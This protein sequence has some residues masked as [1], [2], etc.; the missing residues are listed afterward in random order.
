MECLPRVACSALR[1]PATSLRFRPP[2]SPDN[3]LR[4]LR[5][6]RP[7]GRRTRSSCS[8][9]LRSVSRTVCCTWG[10]LMPRCPAAS[11]ATSFKIRMLSFSTIGLADLAG[12]Q[13]KHHALQDRVGLR[14]IQGRFGNVAQIATG[15]RGIR[16][17]GIIHRQRR[18]IRAA[19][20]LV[21]NIFALRC[22]SA[23]LVA[24]SFLR[25]R[26]CGSLRGV[27]T[28]C[29]MR[30]C[31]LGDVKLVAVGV[32]EVLNVLIGDGDFRDHFAVQQLLDGELAAQIAFQVVH[33]HAAVF[34]LSLKFF[35]GEATFQL[36]EL[37]FHFAV[38]GFEVQLLGALQQDFVVDQ[39]FDYIELAR[40]NLFGRR[41]LRFGIDARAIVLVDFIALY[42]GAIHHGPHVRRMAFLLFAADE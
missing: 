9:R 29:E 23:S 27:I 14:R 24:S 12:L 16:I 22:A 17:L 30:Y 38:A 5:R 7:P 1:R 11:R 41:F 4:A 42:F 35:F 6:E 40:K 19:V 37:V 2:G 3:L 28:I 34:Q 8:L 25:L 26:T 31:G 36:G 39:L 15:R 32:V 33:G 10:S 20:Q 18:K 21:L 13:A